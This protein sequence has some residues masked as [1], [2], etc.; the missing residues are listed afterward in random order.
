MEDDD[1]VLLLK[2]LS[3]CVCVRRA[4]GQLKVCVPSFKVSIFCV[5]QGKYSKPQKI[6]LLAESFMRR[7]EGVAM[8]G[9]ALNSACSGRGICTVQWR[10]Q[11]P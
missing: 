4:A 2:Y 8:C 3:V 5:A 1:G 10:R 6:T 11:A 7:E 9:C